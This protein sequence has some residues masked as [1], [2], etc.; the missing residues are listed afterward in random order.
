MINKNN[1]LYLILISFLL[2][3]DTNLSSS[4]K[5]YFRGSYIVDESGGKGFGGA[6]SDAADGVP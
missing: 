1:I 4:W 5:Q 3:H 6:K 2:S